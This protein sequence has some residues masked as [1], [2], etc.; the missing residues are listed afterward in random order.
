MQDTW[1]SATELFLFKGHMQ[2]LIVIV[3][4]KKLVKYPMQ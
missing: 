3:I 1:I 4:K 2:V